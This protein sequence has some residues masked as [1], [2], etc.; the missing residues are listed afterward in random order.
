V[1]DPPDEAGEAEPA[2]VV[3]HLTGGVGGRAA[4]RSSRRGGSCW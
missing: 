4:G 2:Q 3:G 1:L